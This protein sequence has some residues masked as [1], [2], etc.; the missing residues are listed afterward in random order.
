MPQPLVHDQHPAAAFLFQF[1]RE[2]QEDVSPERYAA[3]A[4]A[5]SASVM[6]LRF[7]DADNQGFLSDAVRAVN[8]ATMLRTTRGD[9][10]NAACGQLV[11]QVQDRTRRQ[12]RYIARLQSQKNK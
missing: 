12:E 8:Y 10:I 2:R 1:C 3:A 9:D 7:L 6:A 11:G 5:W 4:F